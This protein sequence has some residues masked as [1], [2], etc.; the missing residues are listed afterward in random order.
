M[1][2]L[3]RTV[4][5]V[6]AAFVFTEL[7]AR[8]ELRHPVFAHT[9]TGPGVFI[10]FAI[11]LVLHINFWGNSPLPDYLITG[12]NTLIYAGLMSLLLKLWEHRPWRHD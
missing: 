3:L 11:C 4:L 10:T 12:F 8:A 7:A 5:I 6:L 9:V 2:R 1:S